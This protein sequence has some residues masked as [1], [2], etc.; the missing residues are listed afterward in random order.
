MP[1]DPSPP[2]VQREPLPTD[3]AELRAIVEQLEQQNRMGRE[4]EVRLTIE[5]D[6]VH[7]E[8]QEVSFNNTRSPPPE[9]EPKSRWSNL[10]GR[11]RSMLGRKKPRR[12]ATPAEPRE[13]EIEVRIGKC[14]ELIED[15]E[16]IY[17]AIATDPPY[18][19][20][21]H[22][23]NGIAPD[24]T[25]SPDLWNRLFR[26]LKPGGYA[27]V[28]AAPRMYHR[29]ATACEAAGFTIYPFMGWRFRDGLPKPINL[30]ELFD[31]DNLDERKIIGYRRGSGFTQANVDH[32]AQTRTHVNFAIHDRHVSEEAQ[33]WRG[34][35]YGVNALKPCMEPVILAQKPISTERVID[36]VRL[37]G[38]GAL[39][40][41][42]LRDRYGFWPTSLFTH[43]KA[44][45]TDH[46]SDHPSVKPLPLMEDIVTLVCPAGGRILDPF[47]GTGTTGV[48]ARNRGYDCVMIEQDEKMREVIER[49][50]YGLVPA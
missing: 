26:V 29:V 11:F 34:Y 31:R 35:F 1:P 43:R 20:S 42:A 22:G 15:K 45:K 44:E 30:A 14:L 49:R 2:P 33:A 21:L 17:D 36:N 4:R 46:N 10:T 19:I 37:W 24:I 32:G 12:V 50:L 7:E 18:A 23:Y 41:G 39:N 25:F 47:S 27:A 13:S 16:N 6:L 28:F 5:L 8:L 3:V 38:T 40:V 48:A 9:P